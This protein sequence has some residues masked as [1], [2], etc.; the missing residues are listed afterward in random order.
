MALEQKEFRKK[1]K[2]RKAKTEKNENRKNRKKTRKRNR[3]KAQIQQN[4]IE[5]RN[6]K[7]STK[8]TEQH[9]RKQKR[10]CDEEGRGR[11]KS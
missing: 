7:I 2:Q 10:R 1:R 9:T 8:Q 3:K 11:N 6:L 5:K 4:S